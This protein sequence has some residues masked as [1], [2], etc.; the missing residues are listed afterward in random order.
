M[1]AAGVVLSEVPFFDD[2]VVHVVGGDVGLLFA[3]SP[4][5]RLGVEA[6]LRYHSNLSGIEGLAGTGLENLNDAGDRWSVP[7]SAVFRIG[8]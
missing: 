7:V 8:F 3:V 1:P 6:G 5:V 2:S 4:K